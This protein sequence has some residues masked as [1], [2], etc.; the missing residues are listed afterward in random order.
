M[1]QGHVLGRSL[2]RVLQHA[3][4]LIAKYQHETMQPNPVF[5]GENMRRLRK[6]LD[7][8]E[9]ARILAH[10]SRS[11]TLFKLLA[12]RSWIGERDI[13]TSEREALP[14]V[15]RYTV[16]AVDQTTFHVRFRAGPL[17][18]DLK[19]S[20]AFAADA[21]ENVAGILSEEDAIRSFARE[22]QLSVVIHG[23]SL[24]TSGKVGPAEACNEVQKGQLIVAVNHEPLDGLPF[25]GAISKIS[26]ASW[27]KILTF[28]RPTGTTPATLDASGPSA[29][30][31]LSTKPQ[32]SVFTAS[33][34]VVGKTWQ[35]LLESQQHG[36]EI[37][38]LLIDTWALCREAEGAEDGES[39]VNFGMLHDNRSRIRDCIHEW[40][41]DFKRAN[42][43]K[44]K[45]KE[46]EEIK[47]WYN[48]AEAAT[49]LLP[50]RLPH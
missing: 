23:F 8:R 19:D 30:E 14:D 28:I 44:P 43:R 29:A 48:C 16:E 18:M 49:R 9:D 17:F 2:T 33:T 13:A 50:L 5:Q 25:D 47:E 45:R 3:T 41:L 35:E 11:S 22:R 27:P 7:E 36:T 20:G 31:S 24:P 26:R 12:L 10:P 37:S 46:K 6:R 32:G 38:R 40:E 4:V 42:R 34:D 39:S 21:D 15:A 1:R